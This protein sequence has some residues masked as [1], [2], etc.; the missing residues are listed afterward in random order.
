MPSAAGSPPQAKLSFCP[1]NLPERLAPID[2]DYEIGYQFVHKGPD[3]WITGL[4]LGRDF[5]PKL[6]ADIEFYSRGTFHP[7]QSQPTIDF[8]GAI[9]FIIR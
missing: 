6:E 5:T 3:G 9:K 8:G 2:V 1:S 4:V 7:S